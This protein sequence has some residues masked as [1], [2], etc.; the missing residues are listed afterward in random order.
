MTSD[1]DAAGGL[2]PARAGAGGGPAPGAGPPP[3]PV[4]AGRG[5]ALWLS[6]DGEIEILDPRRV[7]ERAAAEP[8]LLCHA[9][10]TAR[11]LGL[12]RLA[13]YDLLELFAFVRPAAFCAPTPR[14]LALAL[15]LAP[16]QGLEE[17][18]LTLGLAAS[19]LLR[20]MAARGFEDPSARGIAFT[21]T[22]GGWLWGPP[23]LRALGA[24]PAEAEAPRAGQGYAVWERMGEW[25][26][27]APPA[28]PS[29]HPVEPAAARRRLAELVGEDAEMRPQQADYAEAIARAF[30]PR[31][32]EGAPNL[33]L[34]EAGTG[35]GKTLGYIAPA[36]LWAEQNEGAVWLS[37]YTRNLQRQIDDELARLYPQPAE[38]RRLVVVR[39]GRENYLCLLNYAEQARAVALKGGETAIGLGLMARWAGATRDGDMVGGDFPGWL[40]DLIGRGR[41]LGLTDRR[42]E[43]VFSACEFYRKCF[44]EKSVRRAKQA[45]LV[46]ANHALVLIQA[47]LGGDEDG[48][49]P[50]QLVFDE[51]HHLFDAADNAFA[52]HLSGRE[53]TELRRW[54]LGAE[55]RRSASASR[56]HGLKRRLEDLAAGDAK[57]EEG[58]DQALRAARALPGEGWAQ[59][60]AGEGAQGPAEAFLVKVRQ[61]VL[62]RAQKAGEGYSL[63]CET[64]PPVEGLL[65]AAGLLDEALQ[66][67][68]APLAALRKRL[69]AKLD[70][71][72]ESLDS[73]TRRRIEGAA[74]SLEKRALLP[75]GAWRD[76]LASLAEE[77]PPAFVDWFAVERIE[78]REID[79]GFR[80]HWLDPGEPLARTVLARVQ[81]A[82]VTSATL[83]DRSEDPEADWRT[84][85][86][87]SGVPYLAGPALRVRVESP[88]DYPA[89][90]RVFVVTDVRKDDMAQVAAAFRELFL[91]AGGGGLGLFTAISRLKAVHARIAA[92]LAAQGLDLYAQHL[93]GLDVATLVEIFRAE[94][95]SCLLGTDAV[96]DGVDVPGRA[97][98]L[99]VFDRVPWPRPSLIHKARRAGAGGRGY[100][101]RL[102]RMKLR[103]AFG[104]LVRRADDRGVFV[105]LDPMMP[106]RLASAFPSGVPV[107][108]LGLAEAIAETAA[109]LRPRRD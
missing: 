75:L 52:A 65:E 23:L 59:R 56:L 29:A 49:V 74:R 39:K 83:T 36:S 107:V 72:A 60:L 79:V 4:D 109:F 16:P 104:R 90:T 94:P 21:M 100:D 38:K 105:L 25:N 103:Q 41:S 11:R 106:T 67:L 68:Q 48:Q 62:A 24:A 81:G 19:A 35:V 95:D 2:V 99:I 28:Q 30:A 82:V 10:A 66:R 51:G 64:E 54:L 57:L 70:Q 7:A 71:E 31:E 61:Q 8:P 22:R 26:E 108:R 34:A 13:G 1:S 76:M 101:D 98:R 89:L 77:T 63:E 86:Q 55:A 50:Q 87:R 12:E 88:F 14:G 93:D 102:T 84:A 46:V 3:E 69:L 27:H 43:C 96:R 58:L 80:R 45:R 6:S 42:G 85:E 91:A 17:R 53:A 73:E 5:Q 15:G 9:P 37:T 97:L 44:I 33:V 20:E 47:A 92:P 32:R 18:A 40:A 78:G